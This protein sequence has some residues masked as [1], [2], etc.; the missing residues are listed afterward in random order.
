MLFLPASHI[1]VAT[2]SGPVA[3]AY[4]LLPQAPP[5]HKNILLRL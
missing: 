4:M 5:L 2:Y 3:Q 1:V